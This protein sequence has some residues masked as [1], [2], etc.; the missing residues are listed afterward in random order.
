[1]GQGRALSRWGGCSTLSTDTDSFCH[2]QPRAAI[3]TAARARARLDAV[4][5]EEQAAAWRQVCSLSGGA[6]VEQLAQRGAHFRERGA[7]EQRV[8]QVQH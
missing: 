6:A 3:Q 7:V 8:I 5:P 2:M 1:M 4:E